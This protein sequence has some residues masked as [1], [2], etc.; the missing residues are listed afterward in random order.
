MHV[1]LITI[2]D[3]KLEEAIVKFSNLP[4]QSSVFNF[5]QYDQIL[6]HCGLLLKTHLDFLMAIKLLPHNFEYYKRPIQLTGINNEIYSKVESSIE[7]N[8]LQSIRHA[9]AAQ[10]EDL[11]KKEH[12]TVVPIYHHFNDPK[13]LMIFGGV[14]IMEENKS[15]SVSLLHQLTIP[16]SSV[17]FTT[18]RPVYLMELLK[19]HQKDT[20]QSVQRL[21][22]QFG[23]S[24]KQVQK[25][26]KL[27]FGTTLYSFILKLKM[28]DTLQDI[29]FTDLTLKEIA[30]KN[31]FLDYTSMHRI[32]NKQYKFPFKRIP[33]FLELSSTGIIWCMVANFYHV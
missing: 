20:S 9:I 2:L 12:R 16:I 5:S 6:Q 14:S 24:Y 19:A 29:M 25:D 26:S 1:Q 27:Y 22:A 8:T 33:R 28:V 32:F 18:Y 10:H 3:Q 31:N 15:A 23:K 17:E 7:H 30:Y 4:F 13:E 21:A 11:S